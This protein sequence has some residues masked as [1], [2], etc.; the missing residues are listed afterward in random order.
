MTAHRLDNSLHSLA[1]QARGTPLVVTHNPAAAFVAF[2]LHVL[3]W[4]S[5]SMV[6]LA[7][8]VAASLALGYANRPGQHWAYMFRP[9]AL[10]AAGGGSP[11]YAT[12]GF[13]NPP[14]VLLPLIPIAEL[15]IVAGQIIMALA[16]AVGLYVG[17]RRLGAGRLTSALVMLLPQTLF[18][19]AFVNLD[20][21]APIGLLLPPALGLFFVLAK[22]QLGVG[23]AAYW[24][25]RAW[26]R[27]GLVGV[28]L[29]FGPLALAG[30]ASVAMYG[31]WFL[32]TDPG[33]ITT[34]WWNL[35]LWPWTV[36][37]GCL[38]ILLAIRRRYPGLALFGGALLSPYV[39]YYSWTAVA[40]GVLGNRRWRLVVFGALVL[41]GLLVTPP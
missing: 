17:A 3:R 26:Q 37:L 31:P 20:W 40:L 1:G 41:V 33:R 21:L 24:L 4:L 28:A 34:T 23:I 19:Y 2:I 15:P 11:Y 16:T 12:G 32:V 39:A 35:A 13:F 18:T 29:T 22:P 36:P 7:L 9:A 30:L 14:W 5:T 38:L 8:L 27:G 6:G 10:T 25:V